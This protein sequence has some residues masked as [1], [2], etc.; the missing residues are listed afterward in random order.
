MSQIEQSV[1]D[2]IRERADIVDVISQYVTLKRSGTSYKGLCPFHGEKTP[3]FMI[4]PD[5][6][7]YKCF[8]C[9]AG[10][11]VFTF[12]MES[13]SLSFAE[14]VHELARQYGVALRFTE[15]APE[16]EQ[17]RV[18]LRKINQEASLY[19]QSQLKDSEQGAQAR[20]YL[21][22]RGVDLHYQQRFQLGYAQESWSALLEHLRSRGFKDRELDTS[23]LFKHSEQSGRPYDFFRNRI[24]FP[25]ISVNG[26]VLAFGG[27]TLSPDVAAKYINSPE[28]EIYHKG[29]HIY[30]LNLAKKHIRKNDRAIL[31]EGYLDV[32][33]A[34]QFGFEEAVAAL[35]T[36]LTPQQARQLLRFTESKTILMAYD[37]DAAG[38]KA[39]DRGAD[40]LEQV[41]TGT[42]LRLNVI[43][44]PDQEDPD[45]FL[46]QHG[47]EAFEAILKQAKAFTAYYIDKILAQHQSDNPVDKSLAAKSAI[48]ALLKI[49]DPILQDEYVRYVAERLKIEEAALRDQIQQIHKKHY[50]QN[51]KKQ[52]FKKNTGK[53][54]FKRNRAQNQE[55]LSPSPLR[56]KDS[57]FISELGLL[58]LLVEH[59]EQRDQVLPALQ[60]LNFEDESNE[61]LRQYLV[62]TAVGGLKLDW[63]ELFTVFSER[64]M[65]QRLAEIMENQAFQAL[66]FE[67]SLA[68]FSRNVKLK[69]LG[70]QMER[71]S[72]EIQLA[73][74]ST[75][76]SVYQ[77]LMYQ[78]MELTQDYTRLKQVG[79]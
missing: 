18:L 8:G 67:K 27:R 51:R 22:K 72:T 77:A 6:G 28:T 5:K 32:I 59:P 37:A 58:H 33:T 41:T 19:F 2:E 7:I 69:C 10:G 76:R 29:D 39:A 38:K 43:E 15:S 71:L 11:N 78:Y 36:A 75:D 13:Q 52:G 12:L 4:S 44:I 16:E 20:A 17:A 42:T 25:I 65:H 70:K 66:D 40:I 61:E 64:E 55:A 60:E 14:V 45:T 1:I 50:Y 57:G 68:D 46:H 63:Q 26:D 3:S 49:R 21:E 48:E 74:Q 30:G 23:G 56:L 73:E 24:M 9:G 31:M 54:T 79:L 35:G 34:H 47:A 53:N 62:S